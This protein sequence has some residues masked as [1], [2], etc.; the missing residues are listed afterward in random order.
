VKYND[1]ADLLV[2]VNGD[3]N[4]NILLKN[5]DTSKAK[6][7]VEMGEGVSESVLEIK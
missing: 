1:D 3:R 5:I 6:K 2:R 4:G 7:K